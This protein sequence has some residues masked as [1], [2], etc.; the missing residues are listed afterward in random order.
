MYILE[1]HGEYVEDVCNEY[2]CWTFSE[3]LAMRYPTYSKAYYAMKKVNK[4][5]GCERCSI[6][7][8]N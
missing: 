7:K 5:Y 4:K 6:S 8:L 3:S 1:N 2:C